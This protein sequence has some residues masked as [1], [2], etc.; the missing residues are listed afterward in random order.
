[1]FAVI[2]LAARWIARRAAIPPEP[3][4]WLAIG[5]VAVSLLLIVEFTVVLWLQGLTM[6][7]YFARRDPVSG[8]VY[9]VMLGVFAVMPL[10]ISLRRR[11]HIASGSP[12]MAGISASP[13]GSSKGQ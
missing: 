8:T 4:R 9:F 6:R 1:M 12:D 3:A 13:P 11:P 2:F 7:E 10:L 5:F